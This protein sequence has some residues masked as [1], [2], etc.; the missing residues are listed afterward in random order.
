VAEIKEL[1]REIRS[2]QLCG[3]MKEESEAVKLL[4]LAAWPWHCNRSTAS[5]C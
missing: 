3:I 4:A 1:P 2:V 5:L